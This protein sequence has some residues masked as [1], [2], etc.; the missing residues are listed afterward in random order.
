MKK[1][2]PWIFSLILVAGFCKNGQAQTS[3]NLEQSLGT[4]T[5]TLD[6]IKEITFTSDEFV[7]H[8]N[9]E[10]TQIFQLSNITQVSFGNDVS[11]DIN[12]EITYDADLELYPVPVKDQLSVKIEANDNGYVVM[13]IIDMNA[14]IVQ[15]SQQTVTKGTNTFNMNLSDL[16]KG[17]YLFQ[18]R[19]NDNV[20]TQKI[21]KQ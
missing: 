18:I 6:D 10:T 14:T 4:A 11:N 9:D 12:R 3:M 21:I 13:Q 2:I 8:L 17:V 16:N 20:R 19:E 5:Y 7:V 15:I 1:T